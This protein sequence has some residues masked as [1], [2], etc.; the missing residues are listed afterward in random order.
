MKAVVSRLL[1]TMEAHPKNETYPKKWVTLRS[2]E[3]PVNGYWL[4]RFAKRVGWAFD[5][6]EWSPS[7]TPKAWM[8]L[9]TNH[10]LTVSDGILLSGNGE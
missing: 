4:E 1:V 3:A 10:S 2:G 5:H 6:L 9:E 7:R 8:G